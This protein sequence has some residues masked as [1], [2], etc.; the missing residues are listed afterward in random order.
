MD[1]ITLVEDVDSGE[2]CVYE[3]REYMG[4]L[5]TFRTVLL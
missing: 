1:C 4:T 5:C 3:C 2:A